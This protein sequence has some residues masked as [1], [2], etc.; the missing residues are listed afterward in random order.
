MDDEKSV[1]AFVFFCQEGMG[2][3]PCQKTEEFGPKL[4]ERLKALK[5]LL[6]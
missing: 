6:G 4:A 3:P 1:K 2:V 5:E